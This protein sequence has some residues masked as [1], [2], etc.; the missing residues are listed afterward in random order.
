[1]P[2]FTKPK[3]AHATVTCVQ[4]ASDVQMA[5][6]AGVDPRGDMLSG[7]TFVA[8]GPA[9]NYY[10]SAY[11]QRDNT[12]NSNSGDI[13]IRVNSV[14]VATSDTGN[15][16]QSQYKAVSVVTSLSAG[17]VVDFVG[18]LASSYGGVGG[19]GVAQIQKEVSY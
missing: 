6:S 16:P 2:G 10:I 17:D 8:R 19:T 7:N 13:A 4:S 1:M 3:V 5:L 14:V 18:H 15:W 12:V 11:V 9:G